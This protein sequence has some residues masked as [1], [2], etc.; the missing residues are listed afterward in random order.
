M[1]MDSNF[2]RCPIDI[3]KPAR[4]IARIYKSI[5]LYRI[6]F[7]Y[8]WLALSF[9]KLIY[10]GFSI[11]RNAKAWGL[12]SIQLMD[13]SN[14]SI[15]DDFHLI[16]CGRRSAIN[17]FSRAQF[18]VFP[19]ASIVLGR[20]VGLNGTTISSKRSISIGDDTMIAANT[21]IVDSDFHTLWP[22]EDRWKTTTS[23]SDRDVVIG[24]NVWIGMNCLILKGT[25]IGDNSIIGA[26]SVVS[27]EIPSNSLAVGNPARV[28]KFLNT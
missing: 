7:I 10:Q 15:G 13:S 21:I 23:S 14:L 25:V 26:G 18:T 9:F 19:G 8:G 4:L 12:F 24:K 3:K 2:S 1:A 16:S 17:Q 22:P 27:G 28:I 6:P 11:G 20:H 5:F